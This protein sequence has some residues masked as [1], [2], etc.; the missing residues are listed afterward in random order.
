MRCNHRVALAV[1]WLL[2]SVSVA[3]PKN[4]AEDYNLAAKILE[5]NHFGTWPEERMWQI[6]EISDGFTYQ[7]VCRPGCVV[8]PGTYPAKY[9]NGKIVM[10]FAD[11][12]G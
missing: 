9:G 2:C 1:F 6:V 12:K 5:S 10:R 8:I 7:L 4:R 11:R 3:L